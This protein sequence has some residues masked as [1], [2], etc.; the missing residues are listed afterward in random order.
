MSFVLDESGSEFLDFICDYREL[1]GSPKKVTTK[2]PPSNNH[3]E[4]TT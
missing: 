1:K 3:L 2:S 4:I